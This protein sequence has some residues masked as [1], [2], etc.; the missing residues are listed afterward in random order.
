MVEI[1]T[2]QPCPAHI[3]FT[4]DSDAQRRV[5]LAYWG[6]ASTLWPEESKTPWMSITQRLYMLGKGQFFNG[7]LK[8]CFQKKG[9]W[10]LGRQKQQM[11]IAAGLFGLSL[12]S[13]KTR[14]C[15]KTHAS[16]TH[17]TQFNFVSI[18]RASL[19]QSRLTL[20]HFDSLLAFQNNVYLSPTS[21][22]LPSFPHNV[23]PTAR[24]FPTNTVNS[25]PNPT[26]FLSLNKQHKRCQRQKYYAHFW[27]KNCSKLPS[28]IFSWGQNQIHFCSTMIYSS[29]YIPPWI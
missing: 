19:P 4:K 12:M 8:C 18:P 20:F 23:S 11:S 16:H 28:I 6:Q 9:E 14:N 5:Y 21:F 15:A 25:V 24:I 3:S 1:N 26:P 27:K 7:R 22:L 17:H 13:Q 10:M 29:C 2:C